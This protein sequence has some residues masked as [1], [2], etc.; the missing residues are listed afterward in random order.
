MSQ[1]TC[2]YPQHV[3]RLDK[4]AFRPV[5]EQATPTCYRDVIGLSTQSQ[6]PFALGCSPEHSQEESWIDLACVTTLRTV[7]YLPYFIVK[8]LMPS[9]VSFQPALTQFKRP[10]YRCFATWFSFALVAWHCVY[11]TLQG[12]VYLVNDIV[13]NLQR[14]RPSKPSGIDSVDF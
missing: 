1:G 8:I 2:L 14:A 11:R 7:E 13:G 5:C 4:S 9:A 3:G 10:Y 12:L 6:D